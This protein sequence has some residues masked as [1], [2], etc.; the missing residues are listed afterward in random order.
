MANATAEQKIHIYFVVYR[1][2]MTK[3]NYRDVSV[4]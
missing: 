3:T 1:N 4:N 2:M